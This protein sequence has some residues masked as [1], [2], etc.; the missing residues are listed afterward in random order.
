MDITVDVH[1]GDIVVSV[2]SGHADVIII[3]Q[4]HL[5]VSIRVLSLDARLA[6]LAIRLYLFWC[7]ETHC[8][9]RI[10]GVRNLDLHNYPLLYSLPVASMQCLLP[11]ILPLR[12][13][14][15][16]TVLLIS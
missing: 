10:L 4:S 16:Y 1:L 12:C 14:A 13:S 8:V 15:G 3:G 7:Q 2:V 5:H 9:N 6:A 11:S